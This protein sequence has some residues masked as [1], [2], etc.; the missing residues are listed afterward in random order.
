MLALAVAVVGCGGDDDETLKV[1][2]AA[3][4][5]EVLP[6]LDEDAEYSFAASGTLATQIREGAP[7]DVMVSADAGLAQELADEGLLEPPRPL[8]ANTLAILVPEGNPKD[9]RSLDDLRRAGIR[10]VMA[11]EGVPLGDYARELLA[12]LG[13]SDLVGMAASYEND[14][15]ANVGKVALGEAD[16]AIGYTTNADSADVAAVALPASAQPRIVYTISIVSSTDLGGPAAGFVDRA[17]GPDGRELLA[18]G[19]FGP[20]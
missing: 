11:D 9:I 20:P 12:D 15:A 1:F 14:A 3:S 18:A 2:A 7:A 19:G 10:F 4:L 16:A 17:L 5:T 8:A 13:Q 6:P